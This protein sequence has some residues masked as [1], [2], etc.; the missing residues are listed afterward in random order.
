MFYSKRRALELEEEYIKDI[1]ND[2]IKMKP[3][4]LITEKGISG[5]SHWPPFKKNF[6]LDL[7]FNLNVAPL[8]RF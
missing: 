8:L 1:C 3:D 2:I 7:Q 4:L 5:K 6:N